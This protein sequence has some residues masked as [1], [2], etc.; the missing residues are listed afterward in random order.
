MIKIKTK[1]EFGIGGGGLLAFSID[2]DTCKVNITCTCNQCIS[3][4]LPRYS[5]V[6]ASYSN[7]I[8]WGILYVNT[9]STGAK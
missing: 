7:W 3:R 2:D 4:I 1:R 6:G 8:Y 5:I 9:T